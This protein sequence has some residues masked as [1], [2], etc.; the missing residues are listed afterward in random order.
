M[1]RLFFYLLRKY[2]RTEKQRIEIYS[3]LW[4][5]V[6]DEYNEQSGFGNVYN[7]NI[8]FL[9]SNPVIVTLV[10]KKDKG[11]IATIKRGINNSF[12]EAI[13]YVDQERF[14]RRPKQ[15]KGPCIPT[16]T[17]RIQKIR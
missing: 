7:M 6:T 3:R 13:G 10:E 11:E 1:K 4:E 8:E 2:S 5:S 14:K 17:G 16:I 15:K 9:M 12:N